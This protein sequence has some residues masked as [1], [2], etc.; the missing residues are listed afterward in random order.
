MMIILLI[1]M[2]SHGWK[3]GMRCVGLGL[4]KVQ[5]CTVDG[6]RKGRGQRV[7]AFKMK[8]RE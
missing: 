1:V 8:G 5:R 4:G 2:M 3:V 7:G 6:C